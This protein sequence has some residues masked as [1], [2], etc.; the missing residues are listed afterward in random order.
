[1]TWR[2]VCVSYSYPCFLEQSFI[3]YRYFI[4]Q[5]STPCIFW[6]SEI[7]EVKRKKERA[8]ELEGIDL[9]NIVSSSRRRS[10]TSYVPPPPPPKPKKP[11][12]ADGDAGGGDA[13]VV[14]EEDDEDEEEDD[15]DDEED[16]DNEED[17]G[18]GDESQGEEFNEGNKPP[19]FL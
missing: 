3:T 19:T 15:D 1:M 13:D 16:D 9:S 17:N 10:T 2:S 14:E 7:K 18:D 4:V 8:K 11:V 5:Q 6:W 12:E